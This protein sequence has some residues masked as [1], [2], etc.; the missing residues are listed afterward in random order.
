M[1]T[2]TGHDAL[3][4]PLGDAS[5]SSPPRWLPIALPS[6]FVGCRATAAG[7]VPTADDEVATGEPPVPTTD[8]YVTTTTA[9]EQ[10]TRRLGVLADLH[11]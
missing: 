7:A 6:S 11:P 4:P 10:I 9:P 8:N 5:R 3:A 2:N 1:H